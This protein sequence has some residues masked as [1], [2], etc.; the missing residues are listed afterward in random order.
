MIGYGIIVRSARKALLIE[1]LDM[2]SVSCD[3]VANN[4]FYIFGGDNVYCR[5]LL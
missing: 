5:C 1:I 3:Q 2:V 4:L